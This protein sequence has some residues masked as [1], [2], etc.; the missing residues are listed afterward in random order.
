MSTDTPKKLYPLM[1]NAD[2]RRERIREGIMQGV[3][4]AFPIVG[5]HFDL[6]LESFEV[7]RKLFS[8]NDQ[9][10][11][12]LEKKTL[13]EPIRGTIALVDKATGEVIERKK[14]TLAH[15]P[16]FTERHTFILKGN[17]Y[18]VSNQVRIKPGVYT[19]ER[20]NGELEAAFNLAKGKNFRLS[21]DGEKGVLFME[22]A[23]SKIP[24][25]PVLT[26]LGMSH[27]AL[28][29]AWG[30]ELTNVN[31]NYAQGK[32]DR[33]ITL[34]YTKIVSPYAQVKDASLQDKIDAIKASYAS[35]KLDPQVTQVTLGAQFSTVEPKSLILAA[36]KI[37]NVYNAKE[38]PDDRDSLAF[39]TLHTV[40]SF[41][42]ERI[43]KHATKDVV[44]KATRNLNKPLNEPKI[45]TFLANSPFSKSLQSFLTSSALANTPMQ[46]NPMEILDSAV[47]VTSLGEG[48]ISST[49][50]VPDEARDVHG[51]HF[52]MLD[53]VRTPESGKA[54]IDIRGTIHL[55]RDEDGN[56]YTPLVNARTGKAEYVSAD[57]LVQSRVA[58]HGQRDRIKAGKSV[59]V[60]ENG[61]VRS[62]GGKDVDFSM[63]YAASMYSPATNLVPML[64]SAM[65]NRNIMGAK[66]QTQALPLVEREQPYVQ[67]KAWNKDSS[68]ET[69][70]ARMISPYSPIKGTVEKVDDDYI[71]IRRDNTKTASAP[72][73]Q[74]TGVSTPVFLRGQGTEKTASDVQTAV[75]AKGSVRRNNPD[76]DVVRVPYS[77]N[78]PLTS[79]TFVH[80]TLSVKAGDKVE[81]GQSIGDNNFT[82]GGSLALGKNMRVAYMAYKGYNS[83][84]ALVI[85]EGAQRKLTSEHMYK[86]S[87]T[88]DKSITLHRDKHRAYFGS[89]YSR[90]EYARLDD[91]GVIKKGSKVAEG[92]LLIAALRTSQPNAHSQ[93][94]G[95]LHKSLV[96]PFSDA[97]VVWSHHA[98]GEVIDVAVTNSSVIVTVRCQAP[99]EIGDK[100]A[101]RFG[102]KGVV[103]KIVPDSQMIQDE[104][105]RPI[106]ILIT[107]ASINSRVNPNQVV[108]TAL[109]KVVEK[110]GTP[111]VL[112]QQEGF[113]NVQYA[114]DLLKKHGV[115]D[116]ETV[117]DPM[118]GR[119]VPGIMV[120]PQY[121]FKMFKSTDTNYAARGVGP[122][123]DANLQP[124]RGGED[125]AKS[126]G[127][128]EF[129]ALIAH[130]ARSLLNEV[131]AVKSQNND[132]YWRRLQLGLPA[133]PPNENF[134]YNKFQAMLNGA[135]IK[136]QRTGTELSLAPLTDRDIDKMASGVIENANL[137]KTKTGKGA[138]YIEPEV[139]GLFDPAVTGGMS[140]TLYSKIELAEPVVNPIFIEPAR[141]LLG[142][143]KAEFTKLRNDE[144]AGVLK[145][146]LN[147]IDLDAEEKALLA[148]LRTTRGSSRNVAL[149]KIKYIQA[150][151][152]EGLKAGDAYVLS[153]VPVTP[154][155]MRPLSPNP[156]GTTLV[157]DANYLYRD[158]M[159]ANESVKELPQAIKD[160]EGMAAQRAHLHDAVGALFGTNDAVSPQNQGRGVKGH[161]T[162]ITGDGS[163][164]YGFFQS[165]LLKRRQDL[166][167]RATIAPDHTLG[168]DE[169][170]MPEDMAWK[171]Y[172]PFLV[173]RLIQ[174]GSSAIEA[175]NSVKQRTPAA[176][177]ALDYEVQKRPVY[178]NRAPTLHRYNV[179]A[180]YPKLIGGKT[181]RM[182]PFAEAGMNADYDGD[183]VQLHVPVSDAAVRDANSMT[184]S[185]LVFADRSKD[186]LMVFPAH[187]AIIGNFMATSRNAGGPVKKFKT[188]ADA[189]AA[190]NRNEINMDT[191]V[192]I[193]ELK[194]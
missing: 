135:G 97:G 75:N 181:L 157:A 94:L 168:M 86:E 10:K 34:L 79:K 148:T 24:L 184:L 107:S 125:G 111:I 33:A 90:E 65:G 6:N 179:I 95:K 67:V 71:Y 73:M 170:G 120:G 23:T 3:E 38:E 131:A 88:I 37:I 104:Q 18:A 159:L 85:S 149:K 138:A 112:P 189:K 115:K 1:V 134:A 48:G 9:K 162:Q 153:K 83:N 194:K 192:E 60:L 171:T 51:S 99:I 14:K 46:I 176:K 113:D 21:M 164:K 154:P 56:M 66:F 53:F 47:K 102:A 74:F 114:K 40:E 126:I 143:S 52:G 147:N 139:G 137:M 28:E 30:K 175:R 89:K 76:D 45:D 57:K 191:P 11:A 180:A 78:F 105:G 98:Q 41:M 108:E 133:A 43:V 55:A 185:N 32:E 177:R 183:A 87:I 141:L 63:P 167:A 155:I 128:M 22:Y 5:K 15:M 182:N 29:T 35:T 8:P 117:F 140:G 77:T 72:P 50:A 173:K 54:G 193:E 156:D 31:R 69:E 110:T 150:L 12:L 172:E 13:T 145:S 26:A 84:D 151:K 152:R 27:A 4:Q 82:R 166:S 42:K 96:K 58:F 49:L 127:K 103:S 2:E 106:D 64:D 169:V 101:N 163:P 116:K 93:M 119:K 91:G 188:L 92:D 144:G 190:Y 129:N 100:L 158:L 68:V 165:R 122:G 146:R 178:F 20:S 123:Y 7:D 124:S 136:M 80:D 187:E 16:Y 19:R 59:D 44:R 61:K 70:L 36:R 109:A 186:S 132:E 160:A 25:Y 142:H 39:K 81:E 118:T 121:T 161:L 130:N 174:Q 62:I 17:E